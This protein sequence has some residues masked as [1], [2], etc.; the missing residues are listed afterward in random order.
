MTLLRPV[1]HR[2]PGR[3]SGLLSRARRALTTEDPGAWDPHRDGELL[4]WLGFRPPAAPRPGPQDR[5]SSSP[6]S[7]TSAAKA[8]PR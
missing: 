7:G 1:R 6:T 8:W 2:A 5:P 4:D 3:L